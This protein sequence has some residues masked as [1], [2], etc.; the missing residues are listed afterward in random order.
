MFRS[1]NK[2]QMNVTK[3]QTRSA[4]TLLLVAITAA[5]CC[6]PQASRAV[7]QLTWSDEFD[8]SAIDTTK[9]TFENGN[10]NGWG[11]SEREY[12]TSR[13]NNAFVSGGLLHIVA[14]QESFGGFPYTSA[15]MKTQGLS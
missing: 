11:N 12:Y 6:L 15:R 7:W 2:E 13:T 10:N 5:L 9:W 4:P 1:G 3:Q 14:R 8:G